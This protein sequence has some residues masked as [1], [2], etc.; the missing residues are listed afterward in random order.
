MKN[1]NQDIEKKPFL[2]RCWWGIICTIIFI[3]GSFTQCGPEKVSSAKFGGPVFLGKIK[4]GAVFIVLNTNDK[5]RIVVSGGDEFNYDAD[6]VPKGTDQKYHFTVID[7][8][9]KIFGLTPQL[10]ENEM[11]AL[12]PHGV[13]VAKNENETRAVSMA[14]DIEPMTLSGN[15][16]INGDTVSDHYFEYGTPIRGLIFT[17]G[18]IGLYLSGATIKGIIRFIRWRR[19]RG[20]TYRQK[21]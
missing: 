2:R 20:G 1:K 12:W 18:V 16:T 6:I 4:E 21:R 17:F 10:S 11:K 13:G 19:K 5:F 15:Y 9:V 7:N 8:A 3:V 14:Y